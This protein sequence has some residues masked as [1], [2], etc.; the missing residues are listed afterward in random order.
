MA[1]GLF[2]SIVFLV[3]ACT[4]LQLDI[5]TDKAVSQ[6][7]RHFLSL[8]SSP[9]IP[10]H[11]HKTFQQLQTSERFL[12]LVRGL[13]PAYWRFG[14]Q[15]AQRLTFRH[16]QADCPRK[17]TNT[18]RNGIGV[19]TVQSRQWA[20]CL[21]AGLFDEI[22]RLV[23]K[24][25]NLILFDLNNVERCQNGSWDHRNVWQ[26]INYTTAMGYNVNWQLGN[27]MEHR[28]TGIRQELD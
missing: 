12:S 8:G 24:T 25:N 26:L 14:G 23:V 19:D 17:D 15:E 18:R 27:G 11:D 10:I 3:C 1:S 22:Y 5:D 13:S 21:T 2:N 4:A 16:E 7:P 20:L 6:I 28:H 9:K